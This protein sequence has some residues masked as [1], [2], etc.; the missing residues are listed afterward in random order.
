M[1]RFMKFLILIEYLIN[2]LS[3]A[4]ARAFATRT[5]FVMPKLRLLAHLVSVN[6]CLRATSHVCEKNPNACTGS[7][8]VYRCI[9]H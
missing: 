1:A 6:A 3:D 2:Q 4:I 8:M 5:R 9:N 7:I